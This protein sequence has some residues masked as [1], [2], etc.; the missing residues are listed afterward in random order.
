MLG[1][2]GSR[3]WTFPEVLLAPSAKPIMVYKRGKEMSPFA[4]AKNGFAAKVWKNDSSTSRQL[5]DHYEG[6]LILS[7]LE[8][9]TLALDCL[10]SRRT[11]E[12]LPGDHTYAL[13]GLL[14][15]RPTVDSTDSAFQAFAKLSLANDS[16]RL[17]E[18][19]ICTLPAT[20]T[21]QWFC[22]DDAFGAKLWD[23]VPTTQISGVG[24]NDTV[25]LDGAFA[26]NI[27]W[28]SFAAVRYSKRVSWKRKIAMYLLRASGL[29]FWIAVILIASSAPSNSGG[30]SDYSSSG[31][32]YYDR[33]KIRRRSSDGGVNPAF[34]FGIFLMIYSI[35]WIFTS[36]YL[37]R[38][39][40]SGKFWGTQPWFFAFEGYLPIE[41]IE[42]QMFGA[43][44]HRLSWSP[45]GSHL[46]RHRKNEYGECE[47][48]DPTND[49][50][51]RSIVERAKSSAPGEQ[52]V[53]TLVDS[54]TMTI[55][56]FQAAR[57]PIGFLIAGSE[58][59]MQRAIAVSLDWK[60]GTLYRETVLRMET[61]VISK[62]NRIPRVQ[63]GLRRPT[64]PIMKRS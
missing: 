13:M 46:S 25:F 56:L 52:K 9:V 2:W 15:L 33:Y 40:Y 22:M 6:N 3:L 28:K 39:I 49:P 54:Y 7:R 37:L 61:P 8:L 32:S 53:Y 26:A 19:L 60:T 43:M 63:I 34:G 44:L 27:R 47:G 21:Q 38:V 5:I 58:G 55:T 41:T 11:T 20:D 45:F 51:V 29:T 59:G 24:Q 31:S 14:R 30:S 12:Y 1:Q 10:N 18:R 36:P 64:D 42:K 50:R 48:S 23:I 62:M 17:L 57:P 35:L 16:D 4:L